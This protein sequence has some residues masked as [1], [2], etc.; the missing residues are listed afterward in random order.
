MN[1]GQLIEQLQALDPALRVVVPKGKYGFIEAAQVEPG[2][3]FQMA[4][5]FDPIEEPERQGA[6]NA[7]MI[8]D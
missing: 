5:S 8:R 6:P 1:V 7:I 2:I 3:F 4:G